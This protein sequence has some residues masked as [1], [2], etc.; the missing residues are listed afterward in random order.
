MPTT[1][2]A[3][4]AGHTKLV[5]A[6][7]TRAVEVWWQGWYMLTRSDAVPH[8]KFML[9]RP[10][11]S[12]RSHTLPWIKCAR[13]K[14]PRIWGSP[15]FRFDFSFIIQM[16]GTHRVCIVKKLPER[17]Y[18]RLRLGGSNHLIALQSSPLVSGGCTGIREPGTPRY[19]CI[20]VAHL[21]RYGCGMP[22]YAPPV[23]F[24][25]LLACSLR[26]VRKG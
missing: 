19:P 15:F 16:V 24:G 12:P 3:G 14:V 13:E 4:R 23:L 26:R 22:L 7:F 10:G 2:R 6:T 17:D 1:P 18:V 8:V 5:Q 20:A 11:V 9:T 25:L 21:Q